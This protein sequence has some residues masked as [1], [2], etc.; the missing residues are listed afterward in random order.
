MD[1]RLQ[2]LR[3]QLRRVFWPLVWRFA[4]LVPIQSES[5]DTIMILSSASTIC[6]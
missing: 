2:V 3:R 1:E 4:E 5:S 6:L